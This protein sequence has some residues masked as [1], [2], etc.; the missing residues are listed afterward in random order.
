MK[1]RVM[2]DTNVMKGAI[3]GTEVGAIVYLCLIKACHTLVVTEDVVAEYRNT[4][5]VKVGIPRIDL[6]LWYEF[7]KLRAMDPKKFEYVDPIPMPNV[8]I[9]EDDRHLVEC[10][11]GGNCDYLVSTDQR[12][13]LSLK[14]LGKTTVISP[15]EFLKREG[16]FQQ[17]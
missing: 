16:I 13:V 3:L 14:K 2:L 10:A 12:H 11:A 15:E 1:K 6:H 7:N 4:L 9:T 17:S 5:G 8:V